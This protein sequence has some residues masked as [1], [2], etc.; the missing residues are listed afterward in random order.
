ML[1]AWACHLQICCNK[2]NVFDVKLLITRNLFMLN[3]GVSEHVTVYILKFNQS[4]FVW[5]ID[6]LLLHNLALL[7]NLSSRIPYHPLKY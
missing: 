5:L 3:Q 1:M 2:I 4:M 7:N 6:T